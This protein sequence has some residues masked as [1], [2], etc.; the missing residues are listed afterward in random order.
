M[1]RVYI[2]GY[3]QIFYAKSTVSLPEKEGPDVDD[4]EDE[5]GREE[6]SVE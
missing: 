6:S 4:G 5:Q 1:Q 2:M 3:I